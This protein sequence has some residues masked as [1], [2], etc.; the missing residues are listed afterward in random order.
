MPDPSDHSVYACAP[1]P[2]GC[3]CTGGEGGLRRTAQKLAEAAWALGIRIIAPMKK[4]SPSPVSN[5]P[6]S[7]FQIAGGE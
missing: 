1:P 6:C 4:P 5:I 3:A 2:L 7:R